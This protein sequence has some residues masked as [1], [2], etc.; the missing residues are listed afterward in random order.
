MTRIQLYSLLYLS[1]QCNTNIQKNIIHTTYNFQNVRI[2]EDLVVFDDKKNSYLFDSAV[3][4][5]IRLGNFER[6]KYIEMYV[7]FDEQISASSSIPLFSGNYPEASIG[8][9][10]GNFTNSLTGE[11]FTV[12]LRNEFESI[13]FAWNDA[14]LLNYNQSF[15]HII[16]YWDNGIYKLAMN[17]LFFGEPVMFSGNYDFSKP[18][19]NSV[20]MAIGVY[21]SNPYSA[22]TYL[23]GSLGFFFISERQADENYIKNRFENKDFLCPR[24]LGNG[25]LFKSIKY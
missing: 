14:R 18:P 3:K 16:L 8:A 21:Q 11:I 17:G 25:F 13:I 15:H 20:D 12:Y 6:I 19:R 22:S 9:Y 7:S 10:I 23:D 1:N 5:S 24:L 4:S 2:K